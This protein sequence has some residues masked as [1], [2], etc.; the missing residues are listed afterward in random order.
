MKWI[1]PVACYQNLIPD[2]FI[3]TRSLSLIIYT[4]I[5]KRKRLIIWLELQYDF[6]CPTV[7]T[8]Y[9]SE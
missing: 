6:L 7:N 4:N 8:L 2:Y 3:Q 5:C 9:N 1:E